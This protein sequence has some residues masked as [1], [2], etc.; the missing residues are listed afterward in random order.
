MLIVQ[1]ATMIIFFNLGRRAERHV[2]YKQWTKWQ[3]EHET[4][5]REWLRKEHDATT[6]TPNPKGGFLAARGI[7]ADTWDGEPAEVTIR[8]LRDGE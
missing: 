2:S 8:R 1:V 5:I 3:K 4:N 7:F 6:Q